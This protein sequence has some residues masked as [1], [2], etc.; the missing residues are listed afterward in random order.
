MPAFR[1]L[2]FICYL[3]LLAYSMHSRDFCVG[4]TLF[5][6]QCHYFVTLGKGLLLG[7][8]FV[9]I[10]KKFIFSFSKEHT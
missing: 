9:F 1:K 10:D 7:L 8:L 2:A 5:G 3:F 6:V 4:G